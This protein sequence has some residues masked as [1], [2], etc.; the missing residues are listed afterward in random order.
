LSVGCGHF[1]FAP[2]SISTFVANDQLSI[3]CRHAHTDA[4]SDYLNVCS[5]RLL[6]STTTTT[7]VNNKPA[8]NGLAPDLAHAISRHRLSHI[9]CIALLA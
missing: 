7:T 5:V 8:E 1:P 6:H 4:H 3:R 9:S 2:T